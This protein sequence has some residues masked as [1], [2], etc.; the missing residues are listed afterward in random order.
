MNQV[1]PED[2]VGLVKH[3]TVDITVL[4]RLFEKYIKENK[5]ENNFKKLVEALT[6]LKHFDSDDFDLSNELTAET[7]PIKVYPVLMKF[8]SLL[9][10]KTIES[11]ID[12]SS[13]HTSVI[14]EFLRAAIRGDI[15]VSQQLQNKAKETLAKLPDRDILSETELIIMEVK[16]YKGLQS[17]IESEMLDIYQLRS[18]AML[19][20]EGKRK[21]PGG[22]FTKITQALKFR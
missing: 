1:G 3:G 7:K 19:Y 2:L 12:K 18:L 6:E 16:D 13:I 17:L 9:Q 21:D 22:C 14:Q 4:A 8:K 20:Q 11:L 15:T 5:F 10:N